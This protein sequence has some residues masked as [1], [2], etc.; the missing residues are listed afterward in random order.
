MQVNLYLGNDFIHWLSELHEFCFQGRNDFVL[1]RRSNSSIYK[2]TN[3]SLFR[4]YR[5]ICW[6]DAPNSTT[7]PSL[8]RRRQEA[9]SILSVTAS[10][11]TKERLEG[12]Q[13]PPSEWNET[14]SKVRPALK[15]ASDPGDWINAGVRPLGSRLIGCHFKLAL[16][17]KNKTL[18]D[19]RL[20][21]RSSI[22]D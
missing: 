7:L 4:L 5:R 16:A 17:S 14:S 15:T 20:P 12:P 2:P 13:S 11:V 9:R 22:G 10:D 3:P 18:V 19:G 6:I 8:D 1:E 21:S